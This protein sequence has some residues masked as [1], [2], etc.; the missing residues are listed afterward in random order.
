MNSAPLLL[1]PLATMA[2]L[3]AQPSQKPKAE[4]LADAIPAQVSP[5][6][7]A[8]VLDRPEFRGMVDQLKQ[9]SELLDQPDQPDRPAHHAKAHAKIHEQGLHS[10]HLSVPDDLSSSEGDFSSARGLTP[11]DEWEGLFPHY[12]LKRVAMP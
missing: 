6:D 3:S 12:A 2:F 1:V 9:A 4:P 8:A 11:E 5:A 10:G 7:V